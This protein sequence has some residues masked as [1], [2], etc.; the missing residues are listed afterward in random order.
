MSHDAWPHESIS[1]TYKLLHMLLESSSLLKKSCLV[2]QSHRVF[3]ESTQLQLKQQ[4]TVEG[5]SCL[6][7]SLAALTMDVLASSSVDQPEGVSSSTHDEFF[8]IRTSIVARIQHVDKEPAGGH[9]DIQRLLQFIH[10]E[11]KD[12]N[13]LLRL[14]ILILCTK[15]IVSVCLFIHLMVAHGFLYTSVN[16]RIRNSRSSL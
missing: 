12:I 14:L 6:G 4:P 13:V 2:T 9:I 7:F 15:M 3:Q 5:E 10:L 1:P 8:W 11:V 16:M